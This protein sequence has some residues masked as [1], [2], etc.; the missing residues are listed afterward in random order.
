MIRAAAGRFRKQTGRIKN[1]KYNAEDCFTCA[2]GRWPSLR[3]ESTGVRNVQPA[4]TAWCRC[5]SRD[6]CPGR[7]Q[8]CRA[9]DPARPGALMLKNV[10]PGKGGHGS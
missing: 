1:M 7:P 3:R 4:S 2:R 8:C 5:G 9:E 10:L 6:G